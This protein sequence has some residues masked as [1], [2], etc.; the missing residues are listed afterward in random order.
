VVLT[1]SLPGSGCGSG[2]GVIVLSVVMLPLVVATLSVSATAL[3]CPGDEAQ[4]AIKNV[5]VNINDSVDVR[6]LH[7]KLVS[8]KTLLLLH[9]QTCGFDVMSWK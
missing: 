9:K 1:V 6:L 5:S 7:R 2:C 8:T 3:C 4:A